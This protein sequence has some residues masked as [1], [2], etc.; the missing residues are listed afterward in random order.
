MINVLKK[1]SPVLAA[2]LFFSAGLLAQDQSTTTQETDVQGNQQLQS[3]SAELVDNLATKVTINDEQKKEISEA[4]VQYQASALRTESGSTEGTGSESTEE[5]EQQEG[6]TEGEQSG[7]VSGTSAYTE[8]W[9]NNEIESILDDTQKTQWE[10]V[11][12]DFWNQLRDK[13]AA[14]QQGGMY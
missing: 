7:T 8:E 5:T 6:T 10:T 4:I 11:K 12:A 3:S 14:L 13:V 1:V 9:L 2:I